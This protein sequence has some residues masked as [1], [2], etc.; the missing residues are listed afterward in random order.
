[1]A[2]RD[3]SDDGRRWF[4]VQAIGWVR[5]PGAAADAEAF[6]DPFAESTLE[7]LPRWSDGLDGIDGYS[8]LVVLFWLDRA[9]RLRGGGRQRPERSP[10]M[11]ELGV[12]ATRSPR[13][14]NPIGIACPRLSRRE[15][16]RLVVSGIDA[17]DGTPIID[18]KGYAP[19][20]EC[21]PDATVPDW[22]T[23]LWRRHDM[24]DRD[25]DGSA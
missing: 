12:F 4:R 3:R 21:R 23:E 25:G 17:W 15:G 11:P 16:N 22:L 2:A 5:R 14:P 18:L 13:R 24:R 20:D 9:R 8:H 19:R 7:I 6:F 1:M 10:E